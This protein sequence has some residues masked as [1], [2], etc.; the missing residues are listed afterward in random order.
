MQWCLSQANAVVGTQPAW[1]LRRR[2]RGGGLF[3]FLVARAL[4]LAFGLLLTFAIESVL[5][6]LRDPRLLS[7]GERHRFARSLASRRL[8][9]NLRAVTLAAL[10]KRNAVAQA[11]FRETDAPARAAK[12]GRSGP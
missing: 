8:A 1:D 3:L 10:R 12:Q 6:L 2:R 7:E 5:L 9:R 4:L 11:V